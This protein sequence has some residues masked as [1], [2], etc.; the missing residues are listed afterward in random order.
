[1]DLLLFSNL[2]Y[3]L[4]AIL[5]ILGLKK[6]GNATTAPTGNLLSAIGMLVA[7]I[8]AVVSQF[9]FEYIYIIIAVVL[10]SIVGLYASKKV[11]MTAMPEMI[12]LFNGFGGIASLLVVCACVCVC[13]Y[14]DPPPG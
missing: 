6:L 14:H 10:G 13:L 9:D 2:L 8:G 1:M 7:V 3:I 5:F 11:A 12:A 4:A